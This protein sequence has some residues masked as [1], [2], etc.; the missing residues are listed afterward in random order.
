MRLLLLPLLTAGRVL[1]R[2]K[3]EH[4]DVGP[5][6]PR[7]RRDPHAPFV[8]FV[9]L[10]VLHGPARNQDEGSLDFVGSPPEE[11]GIGELRIL[12]GAEEVHPERGH[13]RRVDGAYEDR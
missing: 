6:F 1:S 9:Q 4:L 8:P 11:L 7:H 13:V 2:E 5:G 10:E 3:R 12:D